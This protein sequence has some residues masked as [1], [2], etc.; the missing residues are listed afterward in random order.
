MASDSLF[1]GTTPTLNEDWDISKKISDQYEIKK[2]YDSIDQLVDTFYKEEYGDYNAYNDFL[3]QVFSV[4]KEPD[5]AVPYTQE[6][7]QEIMYDI[8]KQHGTIGLPYKGQIKYPIYQTVPFFDERLNNAAAGSV[9]ADLAK[10]V[11]E[12]Q[13]GGF[14]ASALEIFN[15]PILRIATTLIAPQLTPLLDLGSSLAVGEFPS[16]S[17][18]V[19]AGLTIASAGAT[20]TL[21]GLNTD[22]VKLANTAGSIA[23]GADPLQTLALNYGSAFAKDLNIDEKL[24]S[25]LQNEL[26]P[27]LYDKIVDSVDFNTATADLIA[28][29]TTS[30]ILGSQFGDELVNSLNSDDPNTR[31]LGY[32]GIDTVIGLDKG[33]STEDAIL[34]GAKTYYDKGGE[35]PDLNLIADVSGI[36][37]GNIDLGISDFFNS[38]DLTLPDLMIDFDLPELAD[39]GVDFGKIDLGDIEFADFNGQYSVPELQDLGFNLSNLN[40]ELPIAALVLDEAQGAQYKPDSD[41]FD[42]FTNTTDDTEDTSSLARSLLSRT[43]A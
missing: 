26:D 9:V 29:K 2:T 18:F 22:I 17:T 33:L 39:M 3:T 1:S 34:E 14:A 12:M 40:L 41:E 37:F 21:D 36:D 10:T 6:Q 32:A 20:G 23:D 31:A 38:I 15:N 19:N 35:V 30:E 24:K 13:R 4:D 28:G 5:Y 25:S 43:F 27:E 16:Y 42:I 7:A 8:W 11:E